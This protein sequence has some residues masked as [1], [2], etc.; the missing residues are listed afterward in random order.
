MADIVNQEEENALI[1]VSGNMRIRERH[2]EYDFPLES[3]FSKGC[4]ILYYKDGEFFVC[5]MHCSENG[6]RGISLTK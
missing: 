5:G 6:D 2:I 1:V 4:P 3:P